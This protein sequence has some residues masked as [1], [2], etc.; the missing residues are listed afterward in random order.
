MIARSLLILKKL[1]PFPKDKF[2][3]LFFLMLLGEGLLSS[4]KN[5]SPEKLLW[6][7]LAV[8]FNGVAV[9]FLAKNGGRSIF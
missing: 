6:V 4:D 2:P 8:I 3:F 9:P 1:I 7:L 5:P